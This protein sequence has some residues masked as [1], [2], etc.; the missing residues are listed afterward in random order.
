MRTKLQDDAVYRF[1]GKRRA[2]GK[3][4]FIYM[5]A[6]VNKF[7]RIYYGRVKEYLTFYLQAILFSPMIV[8]RF[9]YIIGEFSSLR[10]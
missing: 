5:T 1:I 9:H 10:T 7:L 4:Y 8:S 2:E 6:G 3:P